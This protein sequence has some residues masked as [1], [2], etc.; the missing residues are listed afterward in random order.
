MPLVGYGEF[1]SVGAC[2]PCVLVCTE[3]SQTGLGRLGSGARGTIS[4]ACEGELGMVGQ[5]EVIGLVE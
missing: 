5:G 1:I 2:A 4:K 3:E